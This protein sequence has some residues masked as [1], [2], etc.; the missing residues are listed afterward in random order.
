MDWGGGPGEGM[1]VPLTWALCA[2]MEVLYWKHV[3]EQLETLRK[4]QRREASTGRCLDPAGSR[5]GDSSAPHR[6]S[7]CT[8]GGAVAAET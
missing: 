1:G 2:D 4:L 8:D 6:C 7:L 5:V 3:K